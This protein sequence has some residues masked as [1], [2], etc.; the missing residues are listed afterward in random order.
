M[1]QRNHASPPPKQEYSSTSKCGAIPH[2][3]DSKSTTPHTPRPPPKKDDIKTGQLTSKYVAKGLLLRM[4]S[5]RLRNSTV[6]EGM[7][8]VKSGVGEGEGWGGLGWGG[9]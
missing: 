5:S 6:P 2:P 8:A 7:G 4:G 1:G 9:V 3:C